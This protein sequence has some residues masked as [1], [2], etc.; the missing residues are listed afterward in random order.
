MS[1]RPL[2]DSLLMKLT[3]DWKFWLGIGLTI[4]SVAAP[5][6]LWRFDLASRAL[7]IQLRSKTALSPLVSRSAPE[8]RVS[9]N[10]QELL[11]PYS[12]IIEI[13]NS[14]SKPILASEIEGQIKVKIS[15]PSRL[16][17]AQIISR[18]PLSLTPL[19]TTEEQ[20]LV[21]APLL[22]NPSDSVTLELLTDRG[23]P[24]FLADARIAGISDILVQ[25]SQAVPEVPGRLWIVAALAPFSISA[26]FM[27]A[28]MWRFPYRTYAWPAIVLA[29][30]SSTG[31]ASFA[32]GGVLKAYQIK[33]IT[34]LIV[35]SLLLVAAG[36]TI[37]R[38]SR[39][40]RKEP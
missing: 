31:L 13:S 22:L 32:V 30:A 6:W 14:G 2:K 15:K 23:S 25:E 18:R 1:S 12:S 10:G 26:V 35:A 3:L 4:L 36:F 7:E 29:A 5:I 38:L 34:A 40:L 24:N 27:L 28:H 21:M 19:V 39:R 20:R 17:R 9:F 11:E 8:L 37:S 16:L 33:S